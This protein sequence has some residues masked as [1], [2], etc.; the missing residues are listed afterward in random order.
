MDD[1]KNKRTAT[2]IIALEEAFL[3]PK[4][5]ELYS[6]AHVA[7]LDLLKDR[8]T[9]VGP[10]RIERMDAAGIDLQVLSHVW[11]GVQTLDAET[12]IRLSK[13]VN[14]WLGRI[15]PEYPTR[16][17]G[18]AM[19]PTQSPKHAADELERTVRQLGFKGALINGHTQGHYL[20][21]DPFSVIFERAQALDVPIYIHPTDPPQAITDVYYRDYPA[22]VTGW[23]WPVETG[24]HLLRLMCSGVFD[25]FPRLKI[26]VGHM[27]ELIPY[28]L[29]RLNTALTLGSWLIAAQSKTIGPAQRKPMQKS[30]LHYMRE[31]VFITTSGVFDHAILNCAL[32]E[33]GIDNIL[34]SVD[35]P[36]RDNFEA[37]D[38]LNTAKLSQEDKEK[39]AHGNAERL[40]KLA[41]ETA[42]RSRSLHPR[43]GSSINAFKAKAK[44]K[45]GRIALSFLV[46]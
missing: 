11:P 29:E 24:T 22:L 20:D 26:I 1:I 27:G 17:A 4:L 13:E 25:R 14:D 37:I 41:S 30:V 46:K 10:A 34:F 12:A 45:L 35:D 3:H 19:L 23:A 5:R 9:D 44:S 21:E 18:F 2:R 39:L 33:L 31:N 16:F 40:L 32:A 15:I 36:M 28:A 6:P 38:F 7:Q 43:L 42:S 8:L